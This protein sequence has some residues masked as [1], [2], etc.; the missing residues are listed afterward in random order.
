MKDIGD[1][2]YSLTIIVKYIIIVESLALSRMQEIHP[3]YSSNVK[4]SE[5]R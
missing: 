3:T 5:R 1:I 2:M 4:L